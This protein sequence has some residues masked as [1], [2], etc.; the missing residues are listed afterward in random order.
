MTIE[1]QLEN[2]SNV[3]D[4]HGKALEEHGKLLQSL[5]V[6]YEQHD[7]HIQRIAEVQLEHGKQL[8]EIKD[9]LVGVTGALRPLP[10]IHD[11]VKR[12]ASEHEARIA[13]LEKAASPQ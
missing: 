1:K 10:E 5:H 7:E 6:L 4:E 3:L 2:Q 11:F 13:A 12:I 8:G 9:Q